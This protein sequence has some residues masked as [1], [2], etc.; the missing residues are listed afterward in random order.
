MSRCSENLKK[1]NQ[2]LRERL[3]TQTPQ[4]L[5]L[6]QDALYS[7]D[8]LPSLFTKTPTT[9]TSDNEILMQDPFDAATIIV[10]ELLGPE[11][12]DLL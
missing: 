3:S 9:D 10:A 1:E 6:A 12:Q 2:A 11:D 4:N 8:I 5:P 7:D